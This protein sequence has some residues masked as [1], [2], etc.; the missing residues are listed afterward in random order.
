MKKIIGIIILLAIAYGGYW[1]LNNKS[2][3]NDAINNANTLKNNVIGQTTTQVDAIIK[4]SIKSVGSVSLAYYVQNRNYG[5]SNQKNICADASQNISIGT[6][7]AGIQKVT[8][9]S[10]S[11]VVDTNFP[12]K[13]FTIIA[14]S[15]VNIGQYYCTDQNGF[16]GLIPNISPTSGFKQGLKCK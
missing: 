1:Y 4:D 9:N 16:V 11:C 8:T 5:I 13:S 2:K 15:T 12:S 10:V 6:I 14:P 3:V 7:I